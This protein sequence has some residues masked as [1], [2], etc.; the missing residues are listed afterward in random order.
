M[1]G[2]DL[3]ENTTVS[4]D[5]TKA[6]ILSGNSSQTLDESKPPTFSASIE[7]VSM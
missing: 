1:S 2:T 4:V 5:Q 7:Q 3:S 6:E